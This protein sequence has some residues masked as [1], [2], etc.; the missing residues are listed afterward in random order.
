MTRVKKIEFLNS[1]AKDIKI[2]AEFNA[3]L[4]RLIVKTIEEGN[5][6]FTYT[7]S[8]RDQADAGLMIDSLYWE[9]AQRQ[10]EEMRKYYDK[11]EKSCL[12]TKSRI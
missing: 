10:F 12:F 4:G 8:S 9:E 5:I 1:K 11:K 3:K 7:T 6:R 2:D